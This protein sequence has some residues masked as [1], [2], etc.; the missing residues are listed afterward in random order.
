FSSARCRPG[1]IAPVG[2]TIRPADSGWSSSS[3]SSSSCWAES[4][5]LPTSPGDRLFWPA[6]RRREERLACLD[7]R[8]GVASLST[9][10]VVV[11]A[12]S[13]AARDLARCLHA[14]ALRADVRAQIGLDEP[15]SRTTAFCGRVN[16]YFYTG[17]NTLLAGL[18]YLLL[19]AKTS[20]ICR[21]L[22]QSFHDEHIANGS[23]DVID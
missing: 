20:A 18:M 7:Q 16:L 23:N 14:V 11:R 1:R 13:E 12:L 2:A 4:K 17:A 8:P 21:L 10:D 9:A 3:F 15:R 19:F 5:D 22:A 6:R